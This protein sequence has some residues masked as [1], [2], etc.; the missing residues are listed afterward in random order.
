MDS[1]DGTDSL[2]VMRSAMDN[3]LKAATLGIM[4]PCGNAT[5][6][7]MEMLR[8]Y[9]EDVRMYEDD[10]AFINSIILE[11]AEKYYAGDCTTQQAADMIQSRCALYLSE[12]N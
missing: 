12:Q 3:C 1:W 2:P 10:D 6:A 9:L 11:E 7:E 8:A 4:R 5:T